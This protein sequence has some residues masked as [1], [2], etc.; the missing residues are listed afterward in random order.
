[1]VTY[2]TMGCME[3]LVA[4]YQ[5]RGKTYTAYMIVEEEIVGFMVSSCTCSFEK[6]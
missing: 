3:I 5:L 6:S 1:V 2:L 4:C